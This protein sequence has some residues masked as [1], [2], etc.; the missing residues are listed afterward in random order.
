MLKITWKSGICWES[1]ENLPRLRW[2]SSEN[3]LRI[4]RELLKICWESAETAE[5]L[6]RLYWESAE[7][8]LRI[9][10]DSAETLLRICWESSEN[11][12]RFFRESAENLLTLQYSHY[13]KYDNNSI[14]SGQ[15]QTTTKAGLRRLLRCAALKILFEKQNAMKPISKPVNWIKELKS[16]LPIA[17]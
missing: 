9:C 13:H 16:D 7:T 4:C 17:L 5:N 11:L 12:L 14:N 2:D 8:L 1:A 6:L 10:W 15:Q 3:L